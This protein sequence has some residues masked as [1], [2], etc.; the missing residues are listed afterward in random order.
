LDLASLHILEWREACFIAADA[1]DCGLCGGKISA[2][3]CVYEIIAGLISD[4]RDRSQVLIET[5]YL[6]FSL[7]NR[8]AAV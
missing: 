6:V 8:L 7:Q 4:D 3:S 1:L 5:L 2:F